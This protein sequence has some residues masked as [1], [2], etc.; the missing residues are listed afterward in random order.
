MGTLEVGKKYVTRSG[1][2]TGKVE[3]DE[4]GL[5]ARI[6]GSYRVYDKAGGHVFGDS[7]LDI[8]APYGALAA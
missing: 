4:I 5:R 7:S 1:K 3:I 8:V 2:V 6:D